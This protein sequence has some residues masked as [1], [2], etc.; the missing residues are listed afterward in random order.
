MKLQLDE[1]T[2]VAGL[3]VLYGE[4]NSIKNTTINIWLKD[5]VY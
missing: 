2:D 5:G 3:A 4:V 1:T